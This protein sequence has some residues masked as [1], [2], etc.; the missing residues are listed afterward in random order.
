MHP[1]LHPRIDRLRAAPTTRRLR[2]GNR[3]LL[4]RT[5]GLSGSGEWNDNGK[6]HAT[7]DGGHADEHFESR[8]S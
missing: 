8:S 4:R 2:R 1:D 5:A 6:L 7:D 3:R